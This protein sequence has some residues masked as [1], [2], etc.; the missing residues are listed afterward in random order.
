MRRGYILEKKNFA[1]TPC[2]MGLIKEDNMKNI[3]TKQAKITV[4]ANNL[5][6]VKAAYHRKPCTS[7]LRAAC[8]IVSKL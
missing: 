6:N 7:K 8:L 4:K 2:D 5:T 3:E 1:T